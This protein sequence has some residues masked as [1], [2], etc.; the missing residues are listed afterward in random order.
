MQQVYARVLAVLVLAGALVACGGNGDGP[1]K[2]G[3][4]GG[5]ATY[6]VE[7]SGFSIGVPT[8]WRVLTADEVFSD[9]ALD[10]MRDAD[11]KLEPILDA[12]SAPDSPFKLIAADP[13]PDDDFATNLNVV[14][15]DVPSGVTREDYFEA[16]TAQFEEFDVTDLTEERVALPAGAAMRSTFEHSLGVDEPLAVL[17]YVLLG[18]ETGS[19]L[20]Y[21]TLPEAFGSRLDE[22][23]RSARSFRID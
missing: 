5:L 23:E 14:V 9:E 3:E 12:M 8:D 21:T 20:T 19:T 6:E 2:V 11:P 4:T 18:K 16:S 10:S 17:Q 13:S 15:E 1:Q 7:S 22:F